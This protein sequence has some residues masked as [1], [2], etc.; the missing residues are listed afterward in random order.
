MT[1]CGYVLLSRAH[2]LYSIKSASA[3]LIFI[4]TGCGAAAAMMRQQ[5]KNLSLLLDLSIIANNIVGD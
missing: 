2:Y 1:L 3:S 4:D 5:A